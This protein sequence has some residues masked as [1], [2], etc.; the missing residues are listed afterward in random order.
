M[1]L[2]EMRTALETEM[3]ALAA[4]RRTA[5]DLKALELLLAAMEVSEDGS[6]SMVI[7]RAF[8]AAIAGATRNDYYVR[9]ADFLGL[10]LIPS[11]A[12]YLVGEGAMKPQEY[13]RVIN[14]DH[15]AIYHAIAAG[16]PDGARE[17]AR[18]H[19]R[20]SYERYAALQLKGRSEQIT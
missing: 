20:S 10:R 16:N 19:M 1:K 11:R 4:E 18:L 6:Q 12:L 14:A 2:L 3:A 17:A 9:F 5:A 13:A 7:D 8:H 15:R